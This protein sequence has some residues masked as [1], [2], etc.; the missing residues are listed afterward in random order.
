[1]VGD[2]CE[3]L[4]HA[5][6]IEQDNAFLHTVHGCNFELVQGAAA[7]GRDMTSKRV[8]SDDVCPRNVHAHVIFAC[9]HG[10]N[11][12]VYELVRV[13]FV[14]LILCTVWIVGRGL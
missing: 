6:F 14:L 12:G 4:E 11:N 2:K 5:F 9:S 13:R 3:E 8:A 10:A 1:M 7:G